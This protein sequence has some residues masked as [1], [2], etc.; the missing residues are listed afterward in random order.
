MDVA[1]V[2]AGPTGLFTAVALARRG[3]RVTVVDRDG[4]PAADG[5]W[6]RRGVMQFH[7]PHGFR[8]QV[9]EAIEA[10]MP[11]LMT[12]L[13]EAGAE[14]IV[15]RGGDGQRARH[16]GLRC[17]REVFERGLRAFAAAQ[18]GVTLRVGHVDDVLR[19]RGRAAG[20]RVDGLRAYADLVVNASG[21]ASRVGAGLRAPAEGGDCGLSYVSRQ[22]RLLP[23][24]E[25]G[26]TNAPVG[27]IQT[28][29]GYLVAVFLHDRRTFSALLIRP[30]DDRRFGVLR[31]PEVFE[32]AALAVPALAAW[33][34]PERSVPITPVLPG[35]RLHNTYRGQLDEHGRVALPGLLHV[36]DAVC[37]T[38]PS[39]GRGIAVALRQAVA[40]LRLIDENPG[41]PAAVACAFDAWCAADVRPWFDDHVHWDADLL[42][43]W[44]GG[45]V[46]VT[47]RLPSDLI[48]EATEADPSLLRV[49]G[50]YM[51]MEALPATLDEVEPR[52]RAIFAR[53]WRPTPHPGPTRDELAELITPRYARTA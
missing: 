20:L 43:R 14:R 16:T 37:T 9:A 40:L 51:A 28:L 35:G 42:R 53:G 21:R 31:F 19:D 50:P 8:P 44:A 25:P 12:A 48:M 23:G 6:N 1:V 45:D 49:V 27:L 41:D 2:G 46:D 11:E 10:E 3:H 36:G 33:V 30:T 15:M 38:T 22:Y 52:A 17:R 18:P 32:T 34:T 47:R 13:D 5:R 24:A 7:H 29:S 4:G 26:P 39:A